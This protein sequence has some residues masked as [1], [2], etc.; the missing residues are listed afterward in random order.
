[1]SMP[2]GY[3]YVGDNQHIRVCFMQPAQQG[4]VLLAGGGH[5]PGQANNVYV[6]TPL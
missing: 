1:M 5:I 6:H 4:V 3:V 2:R